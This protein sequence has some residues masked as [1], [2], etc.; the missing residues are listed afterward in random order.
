[1]LARDRGVPVIERTNEVYAC[2]GLIEDK[3]Q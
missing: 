1:M 2:F 3:A